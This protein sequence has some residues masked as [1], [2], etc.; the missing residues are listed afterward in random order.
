MSGFICDT[1]EAINAFQ[2]RARLGALSLEMKGMKRSGRSAYSIC[3]EVYGYKGSK[4]KV[5]ADMEADWLRMQKG[6]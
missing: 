1:P 6:A 4:A 3:K 5:F 2:F